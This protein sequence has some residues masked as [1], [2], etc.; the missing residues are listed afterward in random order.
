MGDPPYAILARQ[1]E[2]LLM[3]GVD[4]VKKDPERSGD[5]YNMAAESAMACMKGKLANRYYMLAE[6]AY[7]QME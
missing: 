6:E 5:L 2:I 4:G 1:A 7:G 3:E